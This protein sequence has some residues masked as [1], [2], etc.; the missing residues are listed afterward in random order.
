MTGTPAQ[1]LGD[2]DATIPA[3]KE[4]FD[5]YRYGQSLKT[6]KTEHGNY[7]DVYTAEFASAIKGYGSAVNEQVH[8]GQRKPP[9]ISS[10][11]LQGVYDWTVKNQLGLLPTV[12]PS[13]P[14]VA[15]RPIYAF[16]APGSG[17]PNDVGPPNDVGQWV[18]NVLHIN[19]RRLAY[20]IG[21][22]L[23]LM[24]GDPGTSYLE[25]IASLDADLERQ[26]EEVLRAEGMDPDNPN[27]WVD[28]DIEFWFFGYSQSADGIKKSVA[29]LFSGRF[30]K[31][32]SR[33]NGLVLFGDPS[34]QKGPVKGQSAEYNPRG[35]GIARYQAPV[36]LERLTY[37]ITVNGDMYACAGDDTLLPG[38][39]RWFIAAE[40]DLSFVTFSAG[41]V[42]PIIA[43]WLGI[44][45]PLIGGLFGAGGASVVAAATGVGI[46]FL[47]KILATGATEDPYVVQLRNDLSAQGLPTIGGISKVI[48]T[49]A[50]LPGIRSHGEYHLPKPEFGDR[51]GVQVATDV[52][53]SFRR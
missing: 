15:H 46:P 48:K 49:L 6:E 42:I 9:Y 51:T 14:P 43:S 8:K 33:I 31:L 10:A 7:T 26:I 3:A 38:F 16:S 40:S 53:A 4:I 12:I 50:A 13:P 28:T 2:R 35:Y 1:K 30:E 36:W 18:Q 47:T 45:G 11:A 27:T 22:Y 29:R 21:G 37:S 34:R 23:G 19:H 52:V 39:Y 32:R 17:V 25:V 20:P 5:N 44:A 41:I 24:G